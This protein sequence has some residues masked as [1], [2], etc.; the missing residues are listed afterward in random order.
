MYWV[1]KSKFSTI[2]YCIFQ[3]G[4]ES[5][6]WSSI[7]RLPSVV[8][9]S[10]HSDEA[11]RQG[12]I[13]LV[14]ALHR[15]AVVAASRLFGAVVGIQVARQRMS[16]FLKALGGALIIVCSRSSSAERIFKSRGWNW[17]I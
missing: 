5:F 7:I 17:A 3:Y 9:H 16:S 11:S 4:G 15:T 14:A 12:P 6:L 1:M 2:E 8:A 13:V 10:L